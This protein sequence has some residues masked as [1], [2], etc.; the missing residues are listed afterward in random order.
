MTNY[1]WGDQGYGTAYHYAGFDFHRLRKVLLQAG[2]SE[3]S[4]V[5]EFPVGH[6]KDCSRKVS[7]FDGKPI[8][9]NMVAVK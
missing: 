9:L 8:S 1:L 4:Q 6:E 2:F 3:A 5:V 7:T